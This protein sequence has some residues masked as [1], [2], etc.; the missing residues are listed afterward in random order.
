MLAFKEYKEARSQ[1][2][3]FKIS[4]NPNQSL[5]AQLNASMIGKSQR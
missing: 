2:S 4:V 1:L 3:L 5:L